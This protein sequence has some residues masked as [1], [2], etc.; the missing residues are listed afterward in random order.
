MLTRQVQRW[1]VFGG[2]Y[3]T[4]QALRYD[5]DIPDRGQVVLDELAVAPPYHGVLY[6]GSMFEYPMGD[7]PMCTS[8]ND[9]EALNYGRY[10]YIIDVEGV[11]ALHLTESDEAEYLLARCFVTELRRVSRTRRGQEIT[12]I[13]CVARGIG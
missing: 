2:A 9:T 13:W 11:S 12:Y 7:T 5:L 1:W 3:E 4:L 6:R 8:A 10:Q